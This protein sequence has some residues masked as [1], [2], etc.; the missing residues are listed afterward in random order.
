MDS[1]ASSNVMI[2]DNSEGL[3]EKNDIHMQMKNYRGGNTEEE[4][5]EHMGLCGHD[6][7]CRL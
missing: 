3:I 1:S 4:L 7:G 2:Q 5:L 6:M